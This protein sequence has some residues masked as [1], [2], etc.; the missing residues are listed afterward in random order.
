MHACELK[1]AQFSMGSFGGPTPSLAF[2]RAHVA[3]IFFLILFLLSHHCIHICSIELL[4]CFLVDA[5][6]VIDNYFLQGLLRILS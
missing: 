5:G 4:N 1:R 3:N 2:L 6:C